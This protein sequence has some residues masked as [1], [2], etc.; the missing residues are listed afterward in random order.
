MDGEIVRQVLLL[1]GSEMIDVVNDIVLIVF[2]IF[3]FF[4]LIAFVVMALL[5]Y[6]RL[7][8]L[9]ETLTATAARG[10]H[11]LE[12]LSDITEK[13]KGGGAI[14]GMAL[15]GAFS[16]LSAVLGGIMGRRGGGRQDSD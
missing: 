9:I 6:R 5:L 8:T 2:L 16:T 1:T 7:A 10:D 15:R 11:L 3:A 14:P 4:A 12:E 13:V